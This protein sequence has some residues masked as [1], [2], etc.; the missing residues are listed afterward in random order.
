MSQNLNW[1]FISLVSIPFGYLI[2]WMFTRPIIPLVKYLLLIIGIISV[3]VIIYK[4]TER[5][6]KTSMFNAVILTLLITLIM[7]FWRQVW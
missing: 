5:L 2:G 1:R 7:H 4:N 6:K 3:A